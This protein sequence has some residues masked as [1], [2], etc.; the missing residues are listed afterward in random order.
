MT[1][2]VLIPSIRAASRLSPLN[3]TAS[4][5]LCLFKNNAA[6]IANPKA[7]K[8]CTGKI[9]PNL[10]TKVLNINDPLISPRCNGPASD[11]ISA[12]PIEANWVPNVTI[13]EGILVLVTITPFMKPDAIHEIKQTKTAGIGL[14]VLVRTFA[15]KKLER[16]IT[17]GNERS[18]SPVI[19]TNV[20][21]KAIISGNGTVDKKDIYILYPRKTLG[22][23]IMNA[24]ISI[25]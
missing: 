6:K 10:P 18:I 1:L 23:T 11:K 17:P 15:N 13:I 14:P 21:P 7:H 3:I 22:A 16:A 4:P 19:I 20:N 8:D 25:A 12:V 9:P 24:I 2:S 5:N